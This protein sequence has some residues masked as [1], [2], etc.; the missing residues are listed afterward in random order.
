MLNNEILE[1]DKCNRSVSYFIERYCVDKNKSVNKQYLRELKLKIINDPNN[2]SSKEEYIRIDKIKL[3]DYQKDILNEYL[4]NKFL[5]N[6][7]SRQMGITTLY[8][9]IFL[10]E[11]I[12]NNSKKI[13]IISDK[14][15]NS[16]DFFRKLKYFFNN[17]PYNLK[18]NASFNNNKIKFE[19]NS[20]I[21]DMTGSNNYIQ[22]FDILYF[23]NF[24]HIN[25]VDQIFNQI[26]NNDKKIIIDS[27]ANSRYNISSGSLLYDLVSESESKTGSIYKTIRTYWYQI[28]DRNE[29]WKDSE[30][31]LIGYENFERE[32]N[33]K[34]I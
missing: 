28:P 5:I 13:I 18:L 21:I 14:K 20:Q 1:Y 33:L 7:H 11:L 12:F 17:L 4:N 30:I 9:L 3:R 2:L 19:N 29:E 34:F 16:I 22:D 6:L 31:N 23:N 25:K 8:S 10:H 26:K 15:M 24:S 27:S 32:Y